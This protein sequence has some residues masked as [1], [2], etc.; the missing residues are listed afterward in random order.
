[1]MKSI[2]RSCWDHYA[3]DDATFLS[4]IYF[5]ETGSDT[6]L[7]FLATSYY[8]S[9]QL[10]STYLLLKGRGVRNKENKY[11][12]AKCCLDIDQL[13]E[14]ESTLNENSNFIFET[15][16]RLKNDAFG[17]TTSPKT[18]RIQH[19]IEAHKRT[20]QE[21]PLLFTSFSAVK[22]LGDSSLTAE[23]IFQPPAKLIKGSDSSR[24]PKVDI[25]E[26]KPQV[27]KCSMTGVLNRNVQNCLVSTAFSAESIVSPAA[28]SDAKS[29]PKAPK[30][31][32]TRKTVST[33]NRLTRQRTGA[34]VNV[35][36]EKQPAIRRSNRIFQNS[37]KE[38]TEFS[39]TGRP[40][41]LIS[42]QSNL[43]GTTKFNHNNNNNNHTAANKDLMRQARHRRCENS[44]SILEEDFSSMKPDID[45]K[46][47]DLTNR[48]R[49]RLIENMIENSTSHS[50]P[51]LMHRLKVDELISEAG[52]KFNSKTDDAKDK[53]SLSN[54]VENSSERISPEDKKFIEQ[55]R[56]AFGDG[57]ENAGDPRYPY[58]DGDPVRSLIKK[59]FFDVM[60]QYASI[61]S[62][63]NQFDLKKSIAIIDEL[64]ERHKNSPLTLYAMG[65]THFE[66]G[67]FA[68][69]IRCFEKCRQKYD[70]FVK[71]VDYHGV[72]L[73]HLQM[74]VELSALAQDMVDKH[75]YV[76]ETWFAAGNC[77][78]LEK[79]QETAIKFFQRA[80]Q[81]NREYSYAYTLLGHE[82]IAMEE[83][84]KATQAFMAA[85]K[86]QPRHYNAWYGLG[87]IHYKQE[88]KALANVYFMRA[89]AINPKNPV[90]L[91][92]ISLAQPGG[93]FKEKALN[94]LNEAIALA[95]ENT[96]CRYNKAQLL[97][98]DE[99]YDEALAEIDTLKQLAPKEPLVYF[100]AGKIHKKVGNPHVA[101]MHFSWA[102]ELDPR[103]E[104]H[105]PFLSGSNDRRYDEEPVTALAALESDDL[106]DAQ[107]IESDVSV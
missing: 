43:I 92:N 91:C 34:S 55:A 6:A 93:E 30:K 21:N 96:L 19:S 58:G 56:R 80:I 84:E 76:A 27:D 83:Y 1:M 51:P 41:L 71:G 106:A 7:Y 78:S 69:A 20:L 103:G 23:Q 94:Y 25:S 37:V 8:R 31:V 74:S 68:K 33:D 98:S 40:N 79:E 73:W 50:R 3:F 48:S 104:Q 5:H 88:K 15:N 32:I 10:T 87:L 45:N 29:P 65:R 59:S 70:Y 17:A 105:H 82:Y 61:E 77:L 11:L 26:A 39:M 22:A 67:D 81:M 72:A 28:D 38:N 62:A 89:L 18:N 14:A 90:L 64:P 63:L 54:S 49:R 75:P 35:L 24:I 101:L 107:V 44:K 9:G 53:K 57:D 4:E 102:T 47:K 46:E 66:M 95:P 86:Y 52:I 97:F 100:L 85:L 42:R 12:F 60:K 13:A 99:K 16:S 2:I 36:S